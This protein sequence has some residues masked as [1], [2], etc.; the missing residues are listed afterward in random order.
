MFL[1]IGNTECARTAISHPIVN[2]YKKFPKG[3]EYTQELSIKWNSAYEK[4]YE[5]LCQL[6]IFSFQITY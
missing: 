3:N 5:I 2:N 6:K 1:E 4:N